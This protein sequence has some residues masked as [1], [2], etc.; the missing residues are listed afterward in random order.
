MLTARFDTLLG[1]FH[2]SLHLSAEAGKT[3]VLRLL[4]GLLYPDQ[5][6]IALDGVTY[7]DSERRIRIPP[8]ERPFGYVF[9]DYVLFPHLTV[10]ENVAFGLRAQHLPRQMIVQRVGEALE[11]VHL[12]GLDRRRP[13]QL[14]G[15]QQQ[16][17]AIA[18][19][20]SLHP[21]LLLLDEP[22]PAL[23]VQTRREVR[24]HL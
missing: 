10:F 2:L 24:Q 11:K 23:D 20:L 7:F 8:Q 22:L 4:A 15:G 5:G 13:A 1:T 14:S 17:V 18:R 19:A 12:V 16:R 21:K 3:T 6:H 9:Q